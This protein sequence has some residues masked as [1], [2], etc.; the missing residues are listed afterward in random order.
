MDRVDIKYLLDL[1]LKLQSINE[2]ILAR[3]QV[4]PTNCDELKEIFKTCNKM[5]MLDV[6]R[7]LSDIISQ[8][9]EMKEH[10]PQ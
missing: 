1:V 9:E 2:R 10:L 5:D 6:K 8:A 4:L 3:N 7:M